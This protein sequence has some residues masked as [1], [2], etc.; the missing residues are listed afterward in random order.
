MS[1]RMAAPAAAAALT[2]CAA[3]AVVRPAPAHAQSIAPMI[4]EYKAHRSGKTRGVLEVRNPTLLPLNVVLEP[5]S[6]TANE[7][8]DPVYR[9]LD[10]DV[11]V[12]LSATSFRIGPRQNYT[13]GYELEADK[14]PV[15]FT[16]Y[17]TVSV[18]TGSAQTMRVAL[19]LPHTVYLLPKEPLDAAA[20]VFLRSDASRELQAVRVEIKNTGPHY[21]RV[22]EVEV[23]SPHK[24]QIYNGFPL[25]PGYRREL[26]LPWNEPETPTQVVLRFKDSKDVQHALADDARR[27]SSRQ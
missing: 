24:K 17:A 22:R 15:W 7:K 25:F 10:P 5:L 6:F 13:A 14:L 1:F 12:R 3:A 4:V 23:S 9:R 8:G 16:I 27:P 18:A 19:R 21:G 2:V 26:D 20:V 11:R